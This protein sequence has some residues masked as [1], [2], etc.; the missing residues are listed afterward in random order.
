M[1]GRKQTAAKQSDMPF[2]ID[3]FL[4]WKTLTNS[5]FSP[6]NVFTE[7]FC[8]LKAI[9]LTKF[10]LDGRNRPTNLVTGKVL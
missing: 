10:K 2:I 8:L 1:D 5:S 4:C 9:N 7:K 6:M 3:G